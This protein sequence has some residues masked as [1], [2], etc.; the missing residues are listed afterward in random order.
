MFDHIANVSAKLEEIPTI[1]SHLDKLISINLLTGLLFG[2]PANILSIYYFNVLCK[3]RDL[4]TQLYRRICVVDLL[5]CV[6]HLPVMLSMWCGR[7][8]LL[9]GNIHFCIA[10]RIVFRALQLLAI[11]LV[12]L[13]A[14]SRAIVICF[15]FTTPK[16]E[17]VVWA[18][19]GYVLFLVL[20]YAILSSNQIHV[21]DTF[22]AYCY[23]DLGINKIFGKI[24]DQ[25]YELEIGISSFII[26]VSFLSSVYK[27]GK[28]NII[29]TTGRQSNKKQASVTIT[30][31]TGIFL[32][33][34]LPQCINMLLWIVDYENMQNYSNPRYQNIFMKFYTWNISAVQMVVLNAYLSPVVYYSRMQG[35]RDWVR[36]GFS[37]GQPNIQHYISHSSSDGRSRV[38]SV[39]PCKTSPRTSSVN[40]YKIRCS[41]V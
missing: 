9:F 14:L 33:C 24:D 34:N 38:G 20:Q 27:L 29:A 37:K 23:E 8:P 39:D 32:I 28:T 11:F 1:V 13:L 19:R 15:P 7:D 25:L 12:L 4:P 31:V 5:T 3:S 30:I 21:Y 6:S 40:I 35:Y 26:I 16:K 17:P 10:W 36:G 18:F 22:D 41:P 2:V